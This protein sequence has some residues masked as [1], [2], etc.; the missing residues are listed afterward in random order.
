MVLPA[1][2]D[3]DAGDEQDLA[4]EDASPSSQ[5]PDQ[6]DPDEA[7]VV[8]DSEP[9]IPVPEPKVPD[10]EVP[11][12]PDACEIGK[13]DLLALL[14]GMANTTWGIFTF[15]RKADEEGELTG[16]QA[17]CPYHKKNKK[18]GCKRFFNVGD[19]SDPVKGDHPPHAA[20]VLNRAG[21]STSEHSPQTPRQNCGCARL[22]FF[23]NTQSDGPS[24]RCEDRHRADRP[25][26]C[27]S[28]GTQR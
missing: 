13:D 23:S 27:G 24:C 25:R 8:S 19:G 28:A 5:E 7:P 10:P 6:S 1:L 15:T 26:S 20:L 17:S 12:L 3:I 2:G 22:G 21:S 18:T 9:G 14:V 4:I 11:P 16:W